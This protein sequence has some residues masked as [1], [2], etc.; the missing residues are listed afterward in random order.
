M[1]RTGYQINVRTP[2]TWDDDHWSPMY[3]ELKELL[4]SLK[5]REC[6]IASMLAFLD[7]DRDS[8]LDYIKRAKTIDIDMEVGMAK[9]KKRK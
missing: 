6:F 2:Q 7:L 4:P 1:P 3:V 9:K 8:Q 5:E